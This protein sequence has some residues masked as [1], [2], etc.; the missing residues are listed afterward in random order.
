M[1]KL[2]YL[3]IAI[4]T[5]FSINNYSNANYY[6]NENIEGYLEQ[7]LDLSYGIEEYKFEINEIR[8]I[9]FINNNSQNLYNNFRSAE[10]LLKNEFLR[11]YKNNEIDYY[12][13]NGIVDNFNLF[14]YHSNKMFEYLSVKEKNNS[15]KE[16]DNAIFKNYQNSRSYLGKTKNLLK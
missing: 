12:T 11:K 3:I 10:R 5:F 13:M 1:K 6:G 16:L 9:Y 4:F 2:V 8:N 14:V 15:F 7:I